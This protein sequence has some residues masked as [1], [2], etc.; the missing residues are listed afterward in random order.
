MEGTN[1]KDCEQNMKI[2]IKTFLVS[3]QKKKRKKR[4]IK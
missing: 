2:I 4:K 1:R 3:I